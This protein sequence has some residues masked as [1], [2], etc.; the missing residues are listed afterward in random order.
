MKLKDDKRTVISNIAKQGYYYYRYNSEYK[1]SGYSDKYDL[2]STKYTYKSGQDK[3]LEEQ[4]E[5][6]KKIKLLIRK[7]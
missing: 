7:R 2:R 3:V 5:Y 6:D 1:T 4:Y